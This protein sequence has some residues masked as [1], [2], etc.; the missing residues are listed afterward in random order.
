[1]TVLPVFL[2]PISYALPTTYAVDLLRFYA[3]GTRPLVAPA[4]EWAALVVFAGVTVLL[5]LRLFLRT[6]HRMRV[7]G[8]TGQ[9]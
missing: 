8:T 2:Q 7:L 5:G 3:L 9:H 4:L 6:E 1:V